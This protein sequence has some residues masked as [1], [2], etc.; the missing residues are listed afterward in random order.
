[1]HRAVFLD[2]DGV[3]NQVVRRNGRPHPPASHDE[4][5]HLPGIPEA[6]HN[7]KAAGFRLLVVTNQ[8]DVGKGI[9][10][11]EVVEEMHDHLRRRLPIDDVKVCYHVDADGCA[12]RKPRPGM[13]LQAA[14]E[15]GVSLRRSYMVGD[16]WRD[17]E[18]GR[19]AGC[20]TVFLQ[21]HYDE[22]QPDHP[23]LCAASLWEASTLIL[24]A[25]A[26][27]PPLGWD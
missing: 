26:A 5:Q 24:A 27:R 18:A 6:L 19:A 15:W 14:R 8:P 2:R 12:C 7:L 20:T 16:R 21:C 1:M 22:K 11:R 13:L 23:D 9:Q 17:V 25:E 4:L 10:R 3:L